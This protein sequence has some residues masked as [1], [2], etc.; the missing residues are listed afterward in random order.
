MSTM[1]ELADGYDEARVYIRLGI[2]ETQD[3]IA[4]ARTEKER[5]QLNEKLRVLRVIEREL[6]EVGYLCRTYYVK[7]RH[8]RYCL[9]KGGR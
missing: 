4:M 8:P 3:A 7:N 2:A 9:V 6:R 5:S 1:E